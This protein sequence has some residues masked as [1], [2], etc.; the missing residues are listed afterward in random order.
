MSRPWIK[1]CGVTTAEA[2]DAALCARV[3]AIGFVFAD[4]PRRV[5]PDRAYRLSAP[6]RGRLACVA[7][8][9]R[10]TSPEID[11]ILRVFRPDVLQID[12][13]E[14][15]RLELPRT[16]EILPVASTRKAAPPALP[17]R[18]LL[19]R[20]PQDDRAAWDADALG[21]LGR[22][23]RLI[24]AGG[25]DPGNVAAL[26]RSVQPFGVD[27]S[28]GVEVSPGIKGPELIGRFAKAARS[29]QTLNGAVSL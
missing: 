3:D 20:P 7:V 23:T 9:R 14:L 21:A 22:R 2:V 5:T 26:V 11:E 12:F 8:V 24:L 1:V 19:E 17:G 4:S 28:R 25:L 18:L 27:V 29:P 10:A 6:A 15:A 13:D 16:L